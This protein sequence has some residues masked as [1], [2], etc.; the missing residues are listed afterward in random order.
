M[1]IHTVYFWLKAGLTH[2]E[3]EAF[4]K[5]ALSLTSINSVRYG[6]VSTPAST[7]RP[8]IDRSYSYALT[9]IFND[10]AGHDAYQIDPVHDAF[11]DQCARYWNQVRIYDSESI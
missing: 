9:T 6:W 4:V 8:V 2:A 1:F 5:S 11:R 10:L 3:E 7:D